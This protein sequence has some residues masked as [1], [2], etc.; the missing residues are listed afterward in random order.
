MPKKTSSS[1][2]LGFPFFIHKQ[3]EARFTRT[4][5]Q[6][7]RGEKFFKGSRPVRWKPFLAQNPGL[8]HADKTDLGYLPISNL[9][10]G[11]WLARQGRLMPLEHLFPQYNHRFL[12][13]GWRKGMVG[14]HLYSVPL[15]VSIRILFYRRDLLD[16]H[17]LDPPRTWD[18]LKAQAVKVLRD[19]RDPNLTGLSSNLCA[20]VRFSVFL[21]HLWAQA[22]DLYEGKP[23]WILNRRQL[24]K[25]LRCLKGLFDEKVILPQVLNWNYDDAMRE[26]LEGRSLFLHHWSDV[27]RLIHELPENERSRFGWCRL[28]SYDLGVE[29]LSV[30][31]GPSFVIPRQT[32]FPEAAGKALKSLFDD[33]FQVWY[34]RQMGWP[35]PGLK[36]VYAD[37]DLIQSRPYL[38]EVERFL[39]YGKLLEDCTY[40]HG[41]YT[42]WLDIGGQEL[43]AFLHGQQ[44]LSATM[45]RMEKRFSELLPHPAYKGFTAKALEHIELNLEKSLKV[46]AVAKAVKITP[47]HLIRVFKNETGKTPLRYIN[48]MKIERA[49]ALLKEGNLTVGQVA[50]RLGY[51][52]LPH[53]SRLFR[54]FV[55]RTPNE[56]KK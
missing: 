53:F 12:E 32:H 14:D 5:H 1:M 24:E 35:Y 2:L 26:F 45:D 33:E 28:P 49:K 56:Y 11:A 4:L 44:D 40:L 15:H 23:D 43:G 42:D 34:A 38:L 54:E 21:D 7:Y 25:A 17:H 13:L 39:R 29:G 41:N 31:G 52:S 50:Y 22:K 8:L 16:K 55:Q 10:V 36:T 48:E 6:H 51:K 19:E 20:P 3:D 30:V 46:E 9:G 47:E 37:G 18:E 27:I